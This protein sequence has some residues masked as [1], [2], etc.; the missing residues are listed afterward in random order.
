M[1]DSGGAIARQSGGRMFPSTVLVDCEGI[2]RSTVRG[3]IDWAG[4]AAKRLI[5]PL[6]RRVPAGDA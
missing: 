6:L 3:A 2:A 1:C 4:P 5:Q